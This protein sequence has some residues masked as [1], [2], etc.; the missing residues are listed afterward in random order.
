MSD[1]DFNIQPAE[2]KPERK[3]RAT[4]RRS[5]YEPIIDTFLD[6]G[7][8]LVRVETTNLDANYL[9]GQ[10]MK[11]LDLKEVDSV[12]VSVRNKEVYLEKMAL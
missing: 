12:E 11:V 6:S 4:R 7:H 10:L 1:I 9:R 2:E 5:K 3:N 8:S